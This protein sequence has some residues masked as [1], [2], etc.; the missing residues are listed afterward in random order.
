MIW[1]ERAPICRCHAKRAAV[2]WWMRQK[3]LVCQEGVGVCD[4]LPG[5]LPGDGPPE[6]QEVCRAELGSKYITIV[7]K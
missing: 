2:S 7:F 4:P 6:D 5:R 3:W 1:R